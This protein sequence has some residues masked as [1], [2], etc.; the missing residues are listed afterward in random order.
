MSH[1]RERAAGR[2]SVLATPIG[3]LEDITL[4]ALRILREVDGVL[5]EDTRRTRILLRHHGIDARLTSLHSHTGPDKLRRVLDELEGGSHWALVTDAGT[6]GVS[7][8]GVRLVRAA[9][10]AGI[11]VDAIPGP[12]ALTAALSTAGIP[13]D[14]FRFVG[15]LPRGGGKRRRVF[16]VIAAEPGTTVLFES[17]HRLHRTLEEL[18]AWVGE[19]REAA[20]CREITKVHEEV[21][22]GPLRQLAD[23]F[24]NGTRGEITLVIGPPAK[25]KAGAE[26]AGQ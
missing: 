4:R 3:N 24:A 2:L 18:A 19:Q 15:F 11:A 5:A 1:P 17:P 12:S 6:P 8:P 26:H 10:D 7:D 20:V 13:C 21:V 9:S 22:R 23:H 16:E 25:R 14:P